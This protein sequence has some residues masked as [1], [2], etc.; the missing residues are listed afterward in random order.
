MT[1]DS[2]HDSDFDPIGQHGPVRTEAAGRKVGDVASSPAEPGGLAAA[3]PSS[4][5]RPCRGALTVVILASFLWTLPAGA[6]V[7]V[8]ALQCEYLTD[9]LGIDV[10]TPRFTWKLTDTDHARG[11]KQTGYQVRVASSPARLDEGRA[12]IWD[13]GKVQSSQSALVPF[14]GHKLTSGQDCF[15]K[16]RVF[17]KDQKPSAWSS[18]ARFSMGLLE[19]K[20]WTGPWIKHPTAPKEKHIWF[21]KRFTLQKRAASAFIYV[22]SVGYHELY[23]NGHKVDSRVL[24]PSLTRL[25]KR[26][27]YV[28]YDI[29]DALHAGDNCIAIWTGP[30]WSRYEPFKTESALR[31]QL[32]AKTI[33]GDAIALASDPSW[34][35]EISS[36]EDLGGCQS[37]NHGGEKIEARK[38]NPDWNA[39]NFDDRKWASVATAA[40]HVTLSAQMI[41]P[42]RV[43]QTLNA[44]SISGNG[45]YKVDLGTNFS[46]WISVKMKNQSAGDVVSIQVSD[47]PGT[48]Q[49]FGQKSIYLCKGG[50]AEMFQNRF[51]YAAGRYLTIEGLK[52]KPGLSD[53]KGYVVGTDLNRVG[54]FSCSSDLFNQIYETDLWTYR[55]DTVEG[56]TQDCPHRERLGYGEEN[57]A[58]AWGC[59]LPNYDTGAFYTKIVRDWCDVQQTNGWINQTAPQTGKDF[60]GAMWSSAPLNVSWEFYKNYGDQRIL[61][62]SYAV[63][64]AWLDF[65]ASHVV[66][67]LLQPYNTNYNRG[68]NFLG[69]W[70]APY[71]K[72]DPL[73]GK[74][75]GTTP[76]ALLFNNCVYAMNLRTFITIAKLLGQPG[77]VAIYGRRLEDLKAKVQAH[78]FNPDQKAYIDHRQ[79][80][81]AF[82][83][84][85]GITPDAV[86]PK[87]FANFEKE[88]LAT[89]PYLDMGSSGLPVLLKF[90]IEDVERNDILFTHLSKTT[91]PSY[92]YFLSR[93]ETTWPEYWDDKCASRIHTCY[94]GIAAWFIK[95]LGG[96][97]EDPNQYGYESFIIKPALVGN[98]TF[99]AARTQSLYGTISSRWEKQGSSIQMNIAIPVNSTATVY[100][101]ATDV[102]TVTE[103][104]VDIPHAKGVI[105]RKMEGAYAVFQVQSG[106]YQFVSK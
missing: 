66:D 106:T 88:I 50:R 19:P 29:K 100:V 12:D 90:L 44:Q 96:I 31:V 22:A 97:R 63:N 72:D 10:Q 13:S 64:K 8:S 68:G 11:Q 60:G 61:A 105:F 17:D 4:G 73:K 23:V 101:P 67:G 53:I 98:L 78:F 82:P 91:E 34:R 74:E 79:I 77:D 62:A 49:A 40:I 95:A 38:Y 59:G 33:N 42:S 46:G 85:A 27:L 26:I 41:E 70:A 24:A 58:T 51:N 76:E 80:H 47:N 65:L 57:F 69:D 52:N 87:V 104:G 94:T 1:K 75:F 21:R 103:S 37:G 2:N 9:P 92:G 16:V 99:A 20:D 32:N 39:V 81:L 25:D 43:I 102:K 5:L 28:A 45:P 7:A 6:A 18:T 3:P 55:A 86:K 83:M 54:H 48:T 71:G 15:W 30:G 14:A 56:Y 89:R 36:S 35:C 93:G 84:F